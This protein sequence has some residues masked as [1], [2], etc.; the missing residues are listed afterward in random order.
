MGF[1]GKLCIHPE[2]IAPVN[3]V[4]TPS[5]ESIDHAKKVIEAFDAAQAAGSASIQVDGYFV[6]YPIVEKAR[7]IL[8]TMEG[9]E[10]RGK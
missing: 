4:F 5:Q 9:I 1:Q 7:R 10:A 6:D 3:A 8:T 2:Q